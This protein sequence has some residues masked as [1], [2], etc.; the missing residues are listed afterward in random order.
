M[1]EYQITADKRIY[2]F[3]GSKSTGGF[4]VTRK[5][6]LAPSRLG[7]ILTENPDLLDYTSKSGAF[8]RYKGRS[9]CWLDISEKG[10]RVLMVKFPYFYSQR[11]CKNAVSG[12]EAFSRGR[13]T[14][15][16]IQNP[17]VRIPGRRGFMTIPRL[18]IQY[19]YR[20]E[21]QEQQRLPS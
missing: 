17:A 20:A 15:A 16:L 4:C 11:P 10:R 21:I 12:Y 9:Y 1:E 7:H 8:I 5:G 13:C 3:T 18:K 6:L 19:R 2:L 14:P